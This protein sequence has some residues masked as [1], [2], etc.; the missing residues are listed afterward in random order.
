METD[1]GQFIEAIAAASR[2][3]TAPFVRL[4]ASIVLATRLGRPPLEAKRQ[5]DEFLRLAEI[6]EVDVPRRS[7]PRLSPASRGLEKGAILR[8]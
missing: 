2:R 4:E 6:V 1:R 8:G 5:F 3:M 7:G